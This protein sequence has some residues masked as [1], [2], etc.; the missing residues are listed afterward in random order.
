MKWVVDTYD[1][2]PYFNISGTETFEDGDGVSNIKIELPQLPQI[3]TTDSFKVMLVPPKAG[4]IRLG[5]ISERTV[6]I[7]NDI[8]KHTISKLRVIASN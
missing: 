5:S 7:T 4:N 6:E 2:S 8:G 3:S 1:E